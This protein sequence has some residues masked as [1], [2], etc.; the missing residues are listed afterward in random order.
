MEGDEESDEP[1]HWFPRFVLPIPSVA[2]SL[3]ALLAYAS[4]FSG[5]AALGL[6]I[7][8]LLAGSLL[9][10]LVH[11]SGHAFAA[12][13]CRWRILVFAVGPLGIHIPNRQL[14]LMSRDLRRGRGGWVAAVPK[15]P[16]ADLA[17]KWSLI[18][19]AGPSANLLLA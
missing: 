16:Q 15:T 11:E 1:V 18:L 2:M 17:W 14:V 6:G 8:C 9:S 10:T 5:E 4:A 12:L 7:G 19:G 13:A 3:W